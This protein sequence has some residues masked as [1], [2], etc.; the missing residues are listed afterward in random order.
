MGKTKTKKNYPANYN[1]K[2]YT[3][4]TI[5]EKSIHATHS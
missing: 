1:I 2:I 3:I 4:N 5:N